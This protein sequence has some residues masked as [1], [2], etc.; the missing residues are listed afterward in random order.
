[1]FKGLGDYPSEQEECQIVKM[2]TAPQDIELERTLNAQDVLTLQDI[3]R[4]V[5]CADHVI[6][7]ATRLT[8]ST[9]VDKGNVPKF[10][11]DYVAWGAGPRA[12][13]N[14]VLAGKARAIL[15]GRYYVSAD[16]IRAVAHPVLRHRVLTNFNAEA[17]GVRSDD[18]IDRL[19][20]EVSAEP[21]ATM[22]PAMADRVFAG[23]RA[24]T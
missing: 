13:Q 1:M 15:K 18:I 17:D 9:R 24:E 21:S 5:P 11:T 16:D 22:D 19:V 8:R 20:S 3:V 10:V 2:T 7:Y 23:N 14:L 4:R 12:S 6:L